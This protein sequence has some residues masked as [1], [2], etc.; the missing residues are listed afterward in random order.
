MRRRRRGVAA[1]VVA[2]VA[3]LVSVGCSATPPPPQ[4]TTNVA[5]TSVPPPPPADDELVVGVDDFGP[6]F[7]PHTL[8][9]VGPVS[10]ALAAASLPSVFQ[11]GADGVWRLNQTLADSAIVT[12]SMPFTVTYRLHQE[13]TW[14]D[15]SPIAAEDFSYLVDRMRTE[16][17]MVNP[18]GYRLISEVN[19]RDGGKTVEVVFR[20]HYPGWRT[21]FTNLLPS[22]LLKDTP[23]G[24]STALRQGVA[25]SGGPFAVRSVDRERGLLVLERNDR[26]WGR[27]AT[28][29]R[30]TLR[31]AEHGELASSLGTGGSQ[32]GMLT[33]DSIAMS[34]LRDLGADVTM[35]TVPQPVLATLR[36]RHDS[37]RLADARVR[38]AVLSAM[39]R[40]SLIAV[41]TGNGPA[42]TLRANSNALPPSS[43]R[44]QATAPSSVLRHDPLRANVLL[45]DAGYRLVDGVWELA[46]EP[47][48]LVI[49]APGDRRPFPSLASRLADQLTTAGIQTEVRTPDGAELYRMLASQAELARTGGNEDA[50]GDGPDRGAELV[51]LVL[52]P[53]MIGGDPASELATEFSCPAGGDPDGADGTGSEPDDDDGS[54]GGDP[55]PAN[56]AAFCDPELQPVIDGLLTGTLQ[57]VPALTEADQAL[58]A[59]APVVPLYQEAIVLVHRPDLVGLGP[60]GLLAG[61]FATAGGWDRADR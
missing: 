22:H 2:A 39:D 14:S 10:L 20:A 57:L 6:G 18:A 35:A 11:Q 15:G 12:G 52:A 34:L 48:R 46:G 58:W 53:R 43:P 24:W 31:L 42:A 56:L 5:Q 44:Y 36:L 33:A 13:A 3:G 9:D 55:G 49:A 59:A 16:P 38:D 23:G 26:Y 51:D 40:D 1:V 28:L 50:D 19:S 29:D 21:L 17:D 37:P 7:N 47:L 27:P 45:R 30:L 25:V 41:G 8:T 4:F 60:G 32:V 61:P 54:D